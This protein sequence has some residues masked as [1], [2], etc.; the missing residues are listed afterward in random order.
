MYRN[1]D[2]QNISSECVYEN[3][4]FEYELG[5]NPTLSHKPTSVDRGQLIAVYC[6][7]RFKTKTLFLKL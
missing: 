4:D 6:V 3:D 7:V 2:V 5:L 1:P